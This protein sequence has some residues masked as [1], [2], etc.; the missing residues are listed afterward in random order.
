VERRAHPGLDHVALAGREAYSP[1][2]FVRYRGVMAALQGFGSWRHLAARF[3]GALSPAGPPPDDEAWA[4]GSLLQGEQDLWRRLSGPDRRHAVG[5]ARDTVSLLGPEEPSRE[6]VAAALLHDAGKVES[7]LG[8]F[9]RVWVTLAALVVGRQRLLQ[10]AASPSEPLTYR[11]RV[12][13]YLSHDRVGARLLESAGSE[14]LTIAWAEE[15]H[16]A[17]ER[18][19][20]DARVGAALKAADGD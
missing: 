17:P 11:A 10:W 1:A 6:I 18:W 2:A 3:F 5:V 19:T 14:E 8:T 4:L 20:V 12:G 16:L 7:S 9:A 13:L 15:H